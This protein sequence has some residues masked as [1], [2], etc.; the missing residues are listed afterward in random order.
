MYS[1][2]YEQEP[3]PDFDSLQIYTTKRIQ[4]ENALRKSAENN[5]PLFMFS[6]F[7]QYTEIYCPF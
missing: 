3:L 2:Y 6:L 4:L 5:K 7:I 1:L